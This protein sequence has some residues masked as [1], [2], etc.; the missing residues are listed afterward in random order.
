[1]LKHCKVCL[2]ERTGG[3]VLIRLV[4]NARQPFSV[5]YIIALLSCRRELEKKIDSGQLLCYYTI[6]SK[7]SQ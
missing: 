7:A 2:Y 4:S 1:M 3:S 6:N 5:L